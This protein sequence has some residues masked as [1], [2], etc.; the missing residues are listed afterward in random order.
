M[1]QDEW[2]RFVDDQVSVQEIMLKIRE[3]LAQRNHEELKD[4]PETLSEMLW[5]EMLGPV[6]E[7]ATQKRIPLRQ[8]E[9]DIVPRHYV[10]EWRIPILGP[11]HALVRRIIND[12]IR[13]YLM[14]SLQRQSNFNLK[15]LRSLRGLAQENAQLRQQ[16]AE[17]TTLLDTH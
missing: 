8:D 2:L 13:R 1:E 9:C 6:E 4:N 17:L 5:H 14:P 16:L 3:R 7:E 12:E 15:V 10:I 11:L